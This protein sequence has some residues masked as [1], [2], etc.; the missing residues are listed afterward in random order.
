MRLEF[1]NK[2]PRAEQLMRTSAAKTPGRKHNH[3]PSAKAKQRATN[4]AK[5][6][7]DAQMFR[8]QQAKRQMADYFSGRSDVRP[9]LPRNSP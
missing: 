8:R 1:D 2:V 3:Q 4:K 9:S 5:T 7:N 6:S